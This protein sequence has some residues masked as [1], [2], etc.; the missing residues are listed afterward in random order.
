MHLV[1]CDYACLTH[2]GMDGPRAPGHKNGKTVLRLSPICQI[3]TELLQ[4]VWNEAVQ[5][6]VK[7]S[8][9][10]TVIRRLEKL[11]GA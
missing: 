4:A 3:K 7:V 10:R 5:D 1:D 8:H 11:L 2:L 9:G 6:V